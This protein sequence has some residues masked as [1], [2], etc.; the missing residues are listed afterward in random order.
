MKKQHEK[1]PFIIIALWILAGAMIGSMIGVL[2]LSGIIPGDKMMT[3]T[4]MTI[5]ICIG[6]IVLIIDLL[7]IWGSCQPFLRKYIYD[8]GEATE[9]VIEYVREIPRPDQLGADEWTR[10]VRYSCTIRYKGNKK[11]YSKEFAPTH[12]TSKQELYP[13]T[14]KEGQKIA[15]RFLKGF[16]ALSIIDVDK[17]T[18]GRLNETNNDRI[19]LVMIPSIITALYI[20]VII[21]I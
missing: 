13:F 12:L 7:F 6:L 11:E 16:P 19:H 18:E 15:V 1:D 17:L 14:L 3:V 10:K 21:M 9:G 5:K 4:S 8:H 2:G 20:T